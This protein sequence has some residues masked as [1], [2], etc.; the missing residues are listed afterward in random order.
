MEVDYIGNDVLSRPNAIALDSH[1]VYLMTACPLP[2]GRI[3]GFNYYVDD[4]PE[5]IRAQFLGR[6]DLERVG[7]AESLHAEVNRCR[8]GSWSSAKARCT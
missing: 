7:R 8:R 4:L 1:N 3:V 2:T 6:L 5:D